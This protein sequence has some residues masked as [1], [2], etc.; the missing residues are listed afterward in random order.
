MAK[1]WID[2]ERTPPTRDW[3]WAKSSTEAMDLLEGLKI[4]GMFIEEVSFDH[5]LGG[6]DTSMIVIRWMAM[7][8]FW[9]TLAVVHTANPVGRE[10]ICRA[11]DA[12]GPPSMY[13]RYGSNL[14]YY[15]IPKMIRTEGSNELDNGRHSG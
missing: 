2:D 11:L 9:P 1:L 5:D 14:P 4:L 6:T 12:D 7:H 8:N 10:N 13:I 3:L 15:R